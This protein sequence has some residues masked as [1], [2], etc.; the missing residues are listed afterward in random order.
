MSTRT[1]QTV[2]DKEMEICFTKHKNV[3]DTQVLKEKKSKYL[4]NSQ[5]LTEYK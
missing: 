1:Q 5:F 3:T 4:S 2:S